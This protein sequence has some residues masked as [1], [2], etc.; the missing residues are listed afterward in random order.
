MEYIENGSE[1]S[2]VHIV[3]GKCEMRITRQKHHHHS[4]CFGRCVALR[5]ISLAGAHCIPLLILHKQN[6]Y[7]LN[8]FGRLSAGSQMG[9]AIVFPKLLHNI[10]LT[11]SNLHNWHGVTRAPAHISTFNA[12]PKFI[13]ARP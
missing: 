3:L 2:S 10:E 5:R 4:D 13:L 9:P 8:T 1:H 7:K 11:A 6:E 12:S